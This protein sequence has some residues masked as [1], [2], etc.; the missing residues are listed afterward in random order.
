MAYPGNVAFEVSDVQEIP[1]ASYSANFF[2]NYAV[3]T[4]NEGSH[5]FT[6]G[7]V[8]ISDGAAGSSQLTVGESVTVSVIGLSGTF[9][10]TYVQTVNGTP[11]TFLVIQSGSTYRLFAEFQP[12]NSTVSSAA[13]AALPDTISSSSFNTAPFWTCFL[14]STAIAT[15]QGGRAVETLAAGDLVLTQDGRV[16][17]IRWVGRQSV[18]TVF[19]GGEGREP[20]RIAAGAL[21]Q[22]LPAR[23]LRVTSDHALV[24]DGMLVN[25]GALVNGSSITRMTA[26]E[27][28]QQYMVYHIETEA[29]E[30]ILAEGQPTETFLD[31]V[32]R[33]RF[34]N[35][36]EFEA[37]HGEP[38][39]IMAGLDMP[40]VK[41]ARQLPSALRARLGLLRAA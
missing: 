38:E 37:L 7:G 29:H 8:S 12:I 3:A 30:V 10:G 41:S 16:V 13:D 6:V 17:P 18:V 28:G 4:G 9:Q 26:A 39:D 27:L 23:D 36:A 34:H 15:P 33:R 20:V 2:K 19:S 21:G 31:H 25:A 35:Y 14:A 1:L 22:G 40:R 24:L 5:S 32:T 11:V